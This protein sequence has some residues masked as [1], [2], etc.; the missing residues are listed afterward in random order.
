[1]GRK[2]GSFLRPRWF[3]LLSGLVALVAGGLVFWQGVS[4]VFL[5]YAGEVP[6]GVYRFQ[7]VTFIDTDYGIPGRKVTEVLGGPKAV[8]QVMAGDAAGVCQSPDAS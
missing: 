3:Y 8:L 5:C 2:D 1:M 7:L 4:I 6:V